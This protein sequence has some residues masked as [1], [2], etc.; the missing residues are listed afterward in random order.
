MVSLRIQ[1]RSDLSGTGLHQQVCGEVRGFLGLAGYYRK[2]VQN[3]SD[4]A[5]PLHDLTK[6]N[7]QFHW[8]DKPCLVIPV[9]R[10]RH[11][12]HVISRRISPVPRLLLQLMG[13]VM[14]VSKILSIGHEKSS[15]RHSV[16]ILTSSASCHS[17]KRQRKSPAGIRSS[18]S[19]LTVSYCGT[20]GIDCCSK[21]GYSTGNGLLLIRPQ[22]GFMSFCQ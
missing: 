15:V 11:A 3:V 13:Q 18:Y 16:E 21:M 14:V 7:Q 6:K 19:R 20:S 9:S 1:R 4:I 5:S 8:D 22:I 17:K 10:S 12:R 2:F